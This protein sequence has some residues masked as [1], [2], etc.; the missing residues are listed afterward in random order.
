MDAVNYFMKSKLATCE[1]IG[2]AASSLKQFSNHKKYVITVIDYYKGY[3]FLNVISCYPD[4]EF[5]FL[6]MGKHNPAFEAHVGGRYLND[7]QSLSEKTKG[8]THEYAVR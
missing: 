1:L 7:L 8:I 4:I 6:K 2:R 3:N 5:I